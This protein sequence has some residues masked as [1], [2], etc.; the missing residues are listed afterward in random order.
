MKPAL[1]PGSWLQALVIALAAII[2][3]TT[4]QAAPVKLGAMGDSLTDEYW[5][6]GVATYATNWPGLVVLYRG[7]NMGPTAVQAGT[8][9]WG[10]P[11]NA[12]YKYNWA[13]RYHRRFSFANPACSQST[14]RCYR[15]RR[16]S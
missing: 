15:P 9:T 14:H 6:S 2:P 7:V 1:L 10:S 12:G 3:P 16:R 11:R 8:N 4:L 5:D 13:P